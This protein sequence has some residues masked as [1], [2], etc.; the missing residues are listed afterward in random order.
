MGNCVARS[1]LRHKGA[2]PGLPASCCIL[3]SFS[4][5]SLSARQLPRSESSSTLVDPSSLRCG[6]TLTHARPQFLRSFFSCRERK[7]TNERRNRGR[8][9]TLG[10]RRDYAPAP[11]LAVSL[12][13]FHSYSIQWK[14]GIMRGAGSEGKGKSFSRRLPRWLLRYTQMQ[15]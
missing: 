3:Q 11:S 15:S 14:R 5:R 8:E 9:G 4:R 6:T 10:S 7:H 12:G 13:R 2:F 1:F